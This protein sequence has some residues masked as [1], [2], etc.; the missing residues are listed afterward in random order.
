MTIPVSSE[1]PT[2]EPVMNIEVRIYIRQ[3]IALVKPKLFLLFS[4]K[5]CTCFSTNFSSLALFKRSL[6]SN[7]LARYCKIY[8]F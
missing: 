5:T 1:L 4:H 7:I 3:L 6:S 2:E 8:Y